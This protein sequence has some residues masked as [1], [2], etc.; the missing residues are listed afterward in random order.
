MDRETAR[1]IPFKSNVN[2]PGRSR[3]RVFS[4]RFLNVVATAP[5]FKK[6]PE[7]TLWRERPGEFTFDLKGIALAVSRSIFTVCCSVGESLENKHD[8][9]VELRYAVVSL[10]FRINPE[11]VHTDKRMSPF[12]TRLQRR[13]PRNDQFVVVFGCHNFKVSF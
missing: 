6:R 10:L 7:K 5:T 8:F 4:G 2:S 1:A 12:R 11:D 3:H 13:F 9:F